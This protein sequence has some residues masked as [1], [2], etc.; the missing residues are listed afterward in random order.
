MNELLAPFERLLADACTPQVIR[1]IEAGGSPAALWSRIEDSGFLAVLVPEAQGGAGLALR[2]AFALFEL[3]GMHA[4]PLPVGQTL[5]VRALLAQQGGEPPE[6]SIAIAP[7]TRVQADGSLRCP[8]VPCGMVADWV[9]VQPPQRWQL[10]RSADAE[11]VHSG[12]HASLRADLHWPAGARPHAQ[13][14]EGAWTEGSAAITA[15][16]LAGAMARVRDLTVAFANQREQFGKPIGKF[17]AIQHQIAV[18]AEHVAAA[19]IAAEIGC[20]APGLQP[21]PLRAAVAKARASEAATFAAPVA[22]AVHGAIGVTAELD[23]QLYTRR[24][25]EARADYGAEQHW[26]GVL[27]RALLAGDASILDFM[28]AEL[29]PA[30]E[31]IQP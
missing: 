28:R 2:H 15:A 18:V 14:G 10:L 25:H 12:V 16:Q 22:H 29:I 5:W 17:Q 20:T 7:R 24:I 8:A 4:V 13:G 31:E 6:G 26:N 21:L 19:R 23:L 1:A 9:L 11:R 3:E 30:S 27:G